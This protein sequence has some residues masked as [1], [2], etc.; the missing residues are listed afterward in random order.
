MDNSFNYASKH[1][2]NFSLIIYALAW[3]GLLFSALVF[4]INEFKQVFAYLE[5]RPI[6][7]LY[8]PVSDNF[9]KIEYVYS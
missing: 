7:N 2:M 5:I 8:I 4:Y 6:K 3:I 9:C 1:R